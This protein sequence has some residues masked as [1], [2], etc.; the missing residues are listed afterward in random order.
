MEQILL[1]LQRHLICQCC[2]CFRGEG[3]EGENEEVD[4]S[5]RLQILSNNKPHLNVYCSCFK[6][7]QVTDNDYINDDDDV[8]GSEEKGE[9]QEKE[10]CHHNHYHRQQ[11]QGSKDQESSS[12]NDG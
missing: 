3:L 10:S 7:S 2:R 11:C 9:N 8:D 6:S 12:E 4:N 1:F 5:K